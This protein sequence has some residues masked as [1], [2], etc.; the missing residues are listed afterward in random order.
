MSNHSKKINLF[1]FPIQTGDAKPSK[2]DIKKIKE[3]IATY[4]TH[5]GVEENWDVDN[6]THIEAIVRVLKN[7]KVVTENI[8]FRKHIKKIIWDKEHSRTPKTY[9]LLLL[10]NPGSGKSIALRKLGIEIAQKNRTKLI[11]IYLSLKNWY[12]SPDI[13]L[14]EYIYNTLIN[15][16]DGEIR[17]FIKDHFLYL[18]QQRRFVFLLDGFDEIPEVL[19]GYDGSEGIENISK[20]IQIFTQNYKCL[21]LVTSRRFKC[22]AEECYTPHITYFLHPLS[23]FHVLRALGGIFDMDVFRQIYNSPTIRQLLTT[24]LTLSFVKTYLE[25]HASAIPSNSLEVYT[26]SIEGRIDPIKCKEEHEITKQSVLVCA[27][28]IASLANSDPIYGVAT[29]KNV[30]VQRFPNHDMEKA[31]DA[32]VRFR[33]ARSD[34]KSISFIHRS[35]HDYFYA[36]HLIAVGVKAKEVSPQNITNRNAYLLYLELIGSKKKLVDIFG[37]YWKKVRHLKSAELTYGDKEYKYGLFYLRFLID[38]FSNKAEYLQKY[39]TSIKEFIVYQIQNGDNLI[40]KKHALEATSLLTGKDR[41][42]IIESLFREYG[43]E[44]NQYITDALIE[45][46]KLMPSIGQLTESSIYLYHH[47]KMDSILHNLPENLVGEIEA[48]TMHRPFLYKK[49][50]DAKAYTESMELYSSH[51]KG[52]GRFKNYLRLL[53]AYNLL[54]FVVAVGLTFAF[55]RSKPH[56]D[57]IDYLTGIP[58]YSLLLYLI[59][60]GIGF[61]AS[62][63]LFSRMKRKIP[64]SSTEKPYNIYDGLFFNFLISPFMLVAGGYMIYE[65]YYPPAELLEVGSNVPP[66]KSPENMLLWG[67]LLCGFYTAF[68]LIVVPKLRSRGYYSDTIKYIKAYRSKTKKMTR[69]TLAV[70]FYSYKTSLLRKYFMQN[71]RDKNININRTSSWPDGKLPNVNDDDASGILAEIEENLNSISN[72]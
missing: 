5:I 33:L 52:V 7:N 44:H 22:P 40:V 24:P 45:T 21:C 3:S 25:T 18:L 4:I 37:V 1:W 53:I 14:V 10:G 31:I 27:H 9:S 28:L 34:G 42:N 67:Y 26:T 43:L 29:P 8:S 56:H 30:L 63:F 54:A 72:L 59:I 66:Y 50:N 70:Q 38:G 35:I 49:Y 12:K 62:S 32:L 55:L 57:T 65:G 58:L 36:Q 48:I 2:H 71:I 19:S 6:F 15:N 39:Q 61:L 13:S 47:S 46:T 20:E 11:P 41:Q 51:S 60:S 69:A 17:T 16:Q 23:E 64:D 68:L